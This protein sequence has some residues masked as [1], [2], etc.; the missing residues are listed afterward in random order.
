MRCPAA[1]WLLRHDVSWRV[2][3]DAAG[4][5]LA[6]HTLVW[7]CERCGRVVGTTTLPARDPADR[8]RWWARGAAIRAAVDAAAVIGDEIPVRGQI[9]P[10]EKP[11]PR[12]VA[13]RKGGR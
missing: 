13:V 9:R 7:L 4:R 8:A 6:P 2:Q 11:S 5:A 1:L 12:L 3:R 10:R